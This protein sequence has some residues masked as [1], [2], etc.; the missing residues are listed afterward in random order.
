M[1]ILALSKNQD[2]P[3]GHHFVSTEE[4][5][6][7]A[8]SVLTVIPKEEFHLCFYER[9]GCCSKCRYAE[10]CQYSL[11]LYTYTSV[12]EHLISPNIIQVTLVHISDRH[13]YIWGYRTN[14]KHKLISEVNLPTHFDSCD[15]VVSN[16]S[17]YTSAK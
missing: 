9:Q 16:T 1:Q 15:Q 14:P 17:T 6:Q 10:G 4:N 5:E 7:K 13:D 12:K 11:V 8:A 3:R 2:M